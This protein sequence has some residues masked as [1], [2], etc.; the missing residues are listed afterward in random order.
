MSKARIRFAALAGT[1]ALSAAMAG[2]VPAQA[3][4]YA[5][6]VFTEETHDR[7][8]ECGLE[9]WLDSVA[10]VRFRTR[11]GTGDLDGA[12]FGQR[13]YEFTDTVTNLANGEFFTVEGHAIGKDVK[14]TR[15]DGNIFEFT[16]RNAGVPY[17]VRDGHGDVVLRDRGS[18]TTTYLIDTLGDDQPGG[19]LL[20]ETLER[21]SGKRPFF[22]LDE[23]AYCAMVRDLV[24]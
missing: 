2:A 17:L 18:L 16:W 15:V 5:H 12:F 19:E 21:V 9:L 13:N 3:T 6:G 24:G 4:V 11:T 1:L 20:S 14:G 8:D 23:A 22:E 7:A 10:T